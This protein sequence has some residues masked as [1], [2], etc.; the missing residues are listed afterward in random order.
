MR[1]HASNERVATRGADGIHKGFQKPIVGRVGA[2]EERRILG[3]IKGDAALEEESSGYV[4]TGAKPNDATTTTASSVYRA[5]YLSRIERNAIAH[6]V[7]IL[8]RE[9]P[10]RRS[11]ETEWNPH[12]R[13]GRSNM[14]K[15]TATR[16]ARSA[17][18]VSSNC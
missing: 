1:V 11:G 6:R 7:E 8:H 17:D 9:A 2:A 12:H 13:R 14:S 10:P 5:L 16:P 18:I 4:P 3:E 15:H